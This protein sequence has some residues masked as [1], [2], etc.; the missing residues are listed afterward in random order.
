M[1]ILGLIADT[2]IPSRQKNLPKQVLKAFENVDIIIHAGD[3][4]ELSVVVSLENI[5]PLIAVRGNMCK[6]GAQEQFP[7]IR[8]LAVEDKKIG[9]IHGDGRPYGFFERVADISSFT[10]K[11]TYQRS[12]VRETVALRMCTV[13]ERGNVSLTRIFLI[14]V[15]E[16]TSPQERALLCLS[17]GN[18]LCTS[19]SS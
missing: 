12:V 9:V 4:E 17:L 7:E 14:V 8:T 2:H 13:S 1:K 6:L 18:S 5:A 19:L 11:S 16:P 10:V 3:F 15:V